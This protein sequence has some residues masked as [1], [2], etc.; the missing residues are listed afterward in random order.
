[1][2]NNESNATRLGEKLSHYVKV[3]GKQQ[4][5][6]N[7][8]DLSEYE[9]QQM[10]M[11]KCSNLK[12]YTDCFAYML[13]SIVPM[14]LKLRNIPKKLA[15]K[16]EMIAM[17][18]GEVQNIEQYIQTIDYL[19][20]MPY[21]PKKVKQKKKKNNAKNFSSNDRSV[22]NKK[23]TPVKKDE[24]KQTRVKLRAAS[25]SY[26]IYSQITSKEWGSA[27]RPARIK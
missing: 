20:M 12:K 22:L 17:M 10:V 3:L 7:K 9:Y 26:G 23:Y 16:D 8:L 4:K 5:I 27:Y 2:E 24:P 18:H 21:L 13:R 15:S 19:L 14:K 1:M 25:R 6:K 11:G